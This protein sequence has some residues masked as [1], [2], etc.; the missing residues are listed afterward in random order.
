MASYTE[1]KTLTPAEFISTDYSYASVVSGYA[2]TN[3]I[4]KSETSTSMARFN[5]KTG[6]SAE[7]WVYYRFD[8]SAIPSDA[9]INSVSCKA[10]VYINQTNANRI[11]TRTVQMYSGTTAKGSASTMSTSTTALTLTCG[12]WTRAELND[13]RLRLYAK[14]G[15]NNTTTTYYMGLYGASVTINYTWK[16]AEYT[17]TTNI[18]NGNANPTSATVEEGSSQLFKLTGVTGKEELDSLTYNGQNVVSQ[19]KKVSN[20][21]SV[22]FYYEYTVS[23]V[24]SAGTLVGVFGNTPEPTET[25]YQKVNGAWVKTTIA[26]AYKKVNGSWVRQENMASAFDTSVNYVKG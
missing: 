18:T 26:I 13:C 23:N 4:G 21:D 8:T 24:T 12:T 16:S 1:S 25:M 2:A 5:L 15:T 22:T 6:S 17:I 14:R 19:A 10:K 11:N 7:S 20:S 9:T 3:P